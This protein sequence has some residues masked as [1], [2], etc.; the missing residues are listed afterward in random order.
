MGRDALEPLI[1][2]ARERGAGAFMLVRT[3]NPGAA[4]VLDLELA[5]GGPAVGAPRAR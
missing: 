4:D 2:G 3:S 5:T 1:A